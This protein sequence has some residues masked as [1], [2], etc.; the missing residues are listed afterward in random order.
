M[1]TIFSRNLINGPSRSAIAF[2]ESQRR[3][4]PEFLKT[5]LS[6]SLE[7]ERAKGGCVKGAPV[8]VKGADKKL[9]ALGFF[10]EFPGSPR[11]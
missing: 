4:F 2:E 1:S 10:N 6:R 7:K 5:I 3:S 8:L 9:R 11:E